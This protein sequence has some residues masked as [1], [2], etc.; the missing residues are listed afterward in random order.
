MLLADVIEIPDAVHDGDFVLKLSDGLRDEAKIRETVDDYV[1]TPPLEKNLR[2]AL[3]LIGAA[4]TQH[5]SK[6][7]ILHGSFGSGKSHFMAVLHLLL[8]RHAV[9]RSKRE[10]A[11]VVAESDAWNTPERKFL[12]VPFHLL[13]SESL[14]QAV[15]SGYAEHVRALH[16]EAPVPAVYRSERLFADAEQTRRNAGDEL[17][18]EKLGEDEE[19][20]DDGWGGEAWTLR[21]YH[22]ARAAPAG[23]PERDA[24]VSALL[25]GWFPGYSEV[26]ARGK[27]TYVDFDEGLAVMSKH[28]KGLGYDAVVLFLDELI[29]WLAGIA[30]DEGRVRAEFQKLSKL[31]EAR[32]ADRPAPIVSFIARQRDLSELVSANLTGVG[33]VNFED[34]SQYITGRF[35]E[36]RL[37]DQNLVDVAY[38]RVLKPKSADAA[39]EIDRMFAKTRDI[40]RPVMDALLNQGGS[41]ESFRKLY[42]FS[43]AL[44]DTLVEVSHLLSRNRTSLKVMLQMLSR[45]KQTLELGEI[46]PVGD[47]FD[48]VT[49][50]AEAFG[51]PWK[52]HFDRARE[53][54]DQ[55]LLPLVLADHP[56]AQLGRPLTAKEAADRGPEDPVAAAVRGDG[57]LLK[58]ALLASLLPNVEAL[59]DLTA[60]R[61]VALN[62]GV[63]KTRFGSG[64]A[65]KVAQKLAKWASQ[66]GEIKLGGNVD[67]NPTVSIRTEGIDTDAILD[68]A[69]A[70]D[71]PGNRVDIIRK[72]LV[73]ELGLPGEASTISGTLTRDFVW[74]GTKREA[75]VLFQNVREAAPGTLLA[76]GSGNVWKAVV[77]FPIDTA[78]DPEDGDRE[79]IDRFKARHADGTRT[80][81]W[82]PAQLAE[83][84]QKSLGR[85]VKA[86]HVL[87]GDRLDTDYGAR[88]APSERALARQQLE[89][90]RDQLRQRLRNALRAA[91]GVMGAADAKPLLAPGS[92][93][94]VRFESLFKGWT[95]RTP[96][97]AGLGDAF[98]ALLD[99][100]VSSQYPAHPKLG[101]AA[102]EAVTPARARRVWEVVQKAAGDGHRWEVPRAEQDLLRAIAVPLELGIQGDTHFALGEGWKERLERVAGT[103]ETVKDLRAELDKPNPRG[104]PDL[105]SDLVLMAFAATTNRGFFLHGAPIEPLPGKLEDAA[106][107]RPKPLPSEEDWVLA[108][109]A[110]AAVFGVAAPKQ[111]NATQVAVLQSKLAGAAATH[112]GAVDRVA[113]GLKKLTATGLVSQSGTRARRN[114]AAV[115]LIAAARPGARAEAAAAIAAVAAA[116][117]ASAGADPL[118]ALGPAVKAESAAA[119][120]EGLQLDRVETLRRIAEGTVPRRRGDAALEALREA[121]AAGEL[122]VPLGPAVRAFHAEA[123]ATLN[124]VVAAAPPPPPVVQPSPTPEPDLPKLP[125]DE[126][127]RASRDGVSPGDLAELMEG[128]ESAG[129]EV[130]IER[131]VYRVRKAGP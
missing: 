84:E 1:V 48:A 60:E 68:A 124:D 82:L 39:A 23:D 40:R 86:E 9:V 34:L 113:A 20:E 77:D 3:A 53:V 63:V 94:H 5:A 76:S 10:L 66:T 73:K 101:L 26:Q 102:G 12:L 117:R 52:T 43:P 104:L 6:G 131:I 45:Q 16:P 116:A 22:D 122:E 15:F 108:G 81:L 49:E 107:L 125:E 61:L 19:G 33:K 50:G 69:D 59:R 56:D 96:A 112:A 62:W 109:E 30:H 67:T 89:T 11:G 14:E 115:E 8:Q 92:E 75:D 42:P 80:L 25:K 46:I 121:L 54:Y 79:A 38:A 18:L 126:W 65:A 78:A 100:A 13:D 83:A 95:P 47:L 27:E 130:V 98:L 105:L 70:I 17:F 55:K 57:R 44:V 90:Q 93:D 127:T 37:A 36:I 72:T 129:D 120:I 64:E 35:S 31:V 128:W 85:L 24:L 28:A 88:L 91:Y 58:T 4:V 32:K 51:G 41:E 123:Q 114:A 99:Q 87:A 74:R 111:R 21:R 29:L 71:T 2:E 110:A 7:A 103:A 97:T 106:E 118:A 119:A